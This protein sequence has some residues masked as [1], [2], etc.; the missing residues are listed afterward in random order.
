[1]GLFNEIIYGPVNSRRLGLSL[2]VNLSPA[3]GK[4]CTFDC[5]YCECGLN[6]EYPRSSAAPCRSDVHKALADR[7]TLMQ[8]AGQTPDVITFSGNGEPTM[9]PDFAAIID[10]TLQL[11]NDLCPRA[12][13]AVLSNST[14]LHKE[15][16]VRSLMKVDD[17]LMKFDAASDRLIRLIDQ[18]GL[19]GFTAARLT[20]QLCL[21]DGKLIV[22]S[23][24][25]HGEHNGVSVDNTAP[26]DVEL[27]IAALQKIRPRK[28]MIY[29]LD[30]PTP[31]KTIR[32]ASPET[33]A[34]IARKA[35]N[36]GIFVTNS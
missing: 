3:D 16:T 34:L 9:H 4:R 13:V 25:L 35:R 5:I 27:W 19:P 17:N 26:E 10:D 2:G 22:Q 7:L 30:R 28:V 36:V 18:P 24:F 23:I 12:R 15:E 33:L 31:V 6:S 8:N 1:M 21:F 32:R 20:E 14:M 11:R 29:T